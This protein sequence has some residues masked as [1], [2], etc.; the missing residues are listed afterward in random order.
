MSAQQENGTLSYQSPGEQLVAV[1]QRR[2]R[3][4]RIAMFATVAAGAAGVLW[5]LFVFMGVGQRSTAV[6][7]PGALQVIG[8]AKQ[9]WIFLEIERSVSAPGLIAGAPLHRAI[10]QVAV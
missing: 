7:Y 5:V 9:V 10:S 8:N 4:I 2:R 6:E 3:R 1:R